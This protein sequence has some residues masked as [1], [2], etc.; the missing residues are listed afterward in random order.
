[1]E[2]EGLTLVPW[3]AAQRAEF[4]AWRKD[5]PGPVGLAE[6]L[7]APS[8]VDGS[9]ALVF[10]GPADLADLDGERVERVALRVLELNGLGG[11]A[12]KA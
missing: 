10:A 7:V 5:N 12:G 6:R 8:V 2:F 3:T 9:G 1:M 4:L 11:G